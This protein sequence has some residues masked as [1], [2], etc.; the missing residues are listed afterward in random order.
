MAGCWGNMISQSF[1]RRRTDES[2]KS[3]A[4][5]M[6]TCKNKIHEIEMFRLIHYDE[7]WRMPG[8]QRWTGKVGKV[9]G[10]WSHASE[11]QPGLCVLWMEHTQWISG[12]DKLFMWERW[13]WLQYGEYDKRLLQWPRGK[14]EKRK[15]T[16]GRMSIKC[17]NRMRLNVFIHTF[18]TI[19]KYPRLG[20]F[21]Y[22]RYIYLSKVYLP[23]K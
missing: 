13:F 22:P 2:P 23:Y 21:I 10:N 8:V 6:Q 15:E 7:T 4:G 18:A 16:W 9:M 17:I 3:E 1:W 5:R 14:V 11:K 19:V 12:D 20:T